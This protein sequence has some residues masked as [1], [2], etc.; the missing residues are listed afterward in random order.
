MQWVLSWF[1]RAASLPCLSSLQALA[2][3][4]VWSYRRGRRGAGAGFGWAKHQCGSVQDP[5]APSRVVLRPTASLAAAPAASPPAEE[6]LLRQRLNS[7]GACV[8]LTVELSP[9]LAALA[10]ANMK[11]VRRREAA[12]A[13]RPMPSSPEAAYWFVQRLSPGQE[14]PRIPKNVPATRCVG[15]CAAPCEQGGACAAFGR[16]GRGPGR[17]LRPVLA[18][19]K[20]RLHRRH[21][22]ATCATP[23]DFDVY[24]APPPPDRRC[25]KRKCVFNDVSIVTRWK[26]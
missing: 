19:M 22:C 7:K 16:S 12:A 13:T 11:E 3:V 17:C 4:S 25:R 2:R 20:N 6:R 14:A 23:A 1:Q 15:W 26:T 9:E 8:P 21:V 10:C 24:L 18:G 5:S